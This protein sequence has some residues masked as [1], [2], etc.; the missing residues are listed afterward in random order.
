MSSVQAPGAS[1]SIAAT[2]RLSAGRLVLL[3]SLAALGV[4]ATNIMLP[5]FPPIAGDLDVDVRELALTRS[6]FFVVIDEI[7]AIDKDH[8]EVHVEVQR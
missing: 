7:Y 5:A 3:A 6:V 2:P 8:V 1:L 4:L